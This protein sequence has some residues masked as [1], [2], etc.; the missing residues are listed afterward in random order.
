MSLFII[1]NISAQKAAKFN[2]FI[3]EICPNLAQSDVV[4]YH[5]NES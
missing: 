3:S 2:K 1:Q 4:G 5:G